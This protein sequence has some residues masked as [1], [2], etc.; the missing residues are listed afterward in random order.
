MVGASG[1]RVFRFDDRVARWAAAA[2]AKTPEILADPE[3]AHWYRHQR[4]WFVGVDALEN[5]EDGAIDGVPLEGPWEVT[6]PWHR[7]QVSVVFDGYPKQDADESDAA[8]RFRINRCAAH[9]D[10]VLAEGPGK[11]RY[12]REPHSFVLGIA[13]N[14]AEEGAAPLVIWPGS[15]EIIRAAFVE[16]YR[17]IDPDKWADVDVTEG[18][19]Q[20]RRWVFE[21]CA[22]VDVPLQPGEAVL[23]LRGSGDVMTG[24]LQQS[25]SGTSLIG[26]NGPCLEEKTP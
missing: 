3:M 12:L 22:P 5:S 20:A 25:P 4:T 21:R 24:Y 23:V 19:A 7:G 15:H 17:G 13:L 10:G 9:L 26:T 8:H 18:Y 6:G 16:L 11:R 1:F 14:T 2:W